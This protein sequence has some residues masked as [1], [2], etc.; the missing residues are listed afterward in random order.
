MNLGCGHITLV[1]LAVA[2][3]HN[4]DH[5]IDKFTRNKIHKKKT[6]V[7][8]QARLTLC[9]TYYFRS[10]PIVVRWS[11]RAWRSASRLLFVDPQSARSNSHAVTIHPWGCRTRVPSLPFR[12]NSSD[13]VFYD[14]SAKQLPRA[15]VFVYEYW[16]RLK[17]SKRFWAA[18]TLWI[19]LLKNH[20]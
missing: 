18:K 19:L 15:I 8:T 17:N 2:A 7:P 5:L 9:G 3:H 10:W 13:A 1:K 12:F 20:G 6:A 11:H 4:A 14:P 16:T